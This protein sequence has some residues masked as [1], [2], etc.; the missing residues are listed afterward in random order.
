MPTVRETLNVV[1]MAVVA[2]VY[3]RLLLISISLQLLQL[4]PPSEVSSTFV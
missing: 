3:L 1:S 2:L 4:N